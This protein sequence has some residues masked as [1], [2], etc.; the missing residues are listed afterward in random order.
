MI[1]IGTLN[2]LPYFSYNFNKSI[3]L[4]VDVSKKNYWMNCS[5][6]TGQMLHF[7]I[8][9]LGPYCLLIHLSI[10]IFCVITLTSKIK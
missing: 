5:V 2:L 6:D 3:L 4:P 8:S 1:N 10:P 7:V 9:D